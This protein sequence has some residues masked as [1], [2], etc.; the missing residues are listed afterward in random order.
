MAKETYYFSHD[1]NARNDEKILMLRAEHGMEGYGI[2]WALVE[3]MFEASETALRHDR[4]K[5]IAASYS[6]TID[7]LNAVIETCIQEGLFVSD[8]VAFW[9]ESLRRR[10]L[11]YYTIKEKRSDAGKKAMKKRW[12]ESSNGNDSDNS[13]ITELEGCYKTVITK[14]N[15]GK[16]SKV[17][18]IK[19]DNTLAPQ[20]IEFFESCWSM[21]IQ[22]KG[23]GKVSNRSKLRA[24][25][26][27]DEFIEC[28]K[29]FNKDMK[30]KEQQ[31]V[32]H[33]S[34][35]FNSGY[36]DY[37]NQQ[38]IQSTPDEEFKVIRKETWTDA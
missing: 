6:L 23:K 37:I 24:Y 35:F 12:G 15:K 36:L 26:L 31:F 18:E 34:T 11:K 20:V 25:E 13:L 14:D 19:K 28:I 16:E 38:P 2:Y 21:L 30:S 9:S 7:A 32:P 8:D 17:N 33:G 4:V 3:M 29:R 10:K 5:G 22:K 1:A 27:G